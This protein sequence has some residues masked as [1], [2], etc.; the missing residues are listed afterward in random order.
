M[1]RTDPPATALVREPVH[2][3]LNE[4]LRT[5]LGRDDCFAGSRF[6]T[7]RDIARRFG[8]SRVTANQARSKLVIA[9]GLESRNGVGALVLARTVHRQTKQKT[10]TTN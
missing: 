7:E 1:I 5:R 8:V 9:G 3:Q 4:Q 6:L 2:R 10:K